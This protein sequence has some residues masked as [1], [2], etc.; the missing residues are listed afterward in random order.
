MATTL[1]TRGQL[2]PTENP[3]PQ[4]AR[5]VL[6]IQP[7]R[8]VAR[9]LGRY[10]SAIAAKVRATFVTRRGAGD[11]EEPRWANAQ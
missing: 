6:R 1:D 2:T 9:E 3:P 4:P 5:R 10:V 7:T 11:A 8:D